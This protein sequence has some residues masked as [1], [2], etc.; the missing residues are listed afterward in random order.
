[1]YFFSH[2]QLIKYLKKVRTVA[3]THNLSKFCYSVIEIETWKVDRVKW[4]TFETCQLWNFIGYFYRSFTIRN[5]IH[6]ICWLVMEL[7]TRQVFFIV[8]V[9]GTPVFIISYKEFV[10]KKY[11][12]EES[13]SQSKYLIIQQRLCVF[14]RHSTISHFF[15]RRVVFKWN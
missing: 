2:L 4:E 9:L 6:R 12:T 5:F 1:M 8:Y 13:K 15:S 3:V 11:V 7:T 14:S 10:L